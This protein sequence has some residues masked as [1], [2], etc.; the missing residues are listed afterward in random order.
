M[1]VHLNNVPKG[2]TDDK[3]WDELE[4]HV[5]ALGILD[6]Y[7]E[8]PSRR[9]FAWITFLNEADGKRF[10]QKHEKVTM[11]PTQPWS[12]PVPNGRFRPRTKDMARLQI[13]KTPIYVSKSTRKIDEGILLHL[14]IQKDE[15]RTVERKPVVVDRNPK[16]D[17]IST[18]VRHIACGKNMF[19]Q[20]SDD[21]IFI[22]QCSLDLRGTARF[23]RHALMLKFI[24]QDEHRVDIPYDIIQDLVADASGVSMTLVLTEPPRFYPS[25]TKW[26]RQT[27]LGMW[28]AHAKYVAHCL[29]YRITLSSQYVEV[30]ES[31]RSRDIIAVTRQQ[32]PVRRNPRPHEEDY[33]TCMTTFEGSIRS[34]SVSRTR[35][36]PFVVLFQLQGLVWNNYLHP[37]TALKMLEVMDRFAKDCKRSN[38]LLPFTADSMKTLFQKIPYP[39]PGTDSQDL[40]PEHLVASIVE[41]EQLR[42]EEDPTRA[43][44]Y[45]PPIPDSQTW[46]LKAIVT[47]TRIM[48]HG[49][50]AE[51]KN[52][53]LRMFPRHA[54][55]FVRVIFS[56]EDGQDLALFPSVNNSAI[57]E[58]YRKVLKD[59]I[60]IAGRKYDFLGFSHSSLRSH[61]AWFCAPFNDNME[62]HNNDSIIKSLGDFSEIRI[63]AKCAARIGQAFSETPYAV[64]ILKCGIGIKYIPD[65]KTKDG[66]RVFSDGVGTISWD[67]IEE[68]WDHLPTTSA[69][70]CLQVRLAGIKGMLSLDSRLKGKVVCIRKESMMK[71]PSNDQTMLGIC[72][73]ASKPLRLVLNRQ[74]IKILEDMGTNAE[75]FIDQQNKALD[76]LR[77]VTATATNTSTFLEYQL[78]G[79]TVGLPKLIKYLNKI[80]VD[81][82]RDNFMKTVVDHTILEELRLLKYKARIPVDQGVVLFGIMDETGFLEEGEI[83]VTFD[84]Q[85]DKI[86]GRVKQSLRDGFV[87]VTRSPALHPGDI[88]PAQMRTPPQ[89]HPLRDLKNCVVF[90]QKGT[91]DLPSQLSGGDLDGDLYSVFWDPYVIPKQFFEAASY[92]RVSPPSL[93][94]AVTR[95]DIADFF[96]RFMET[97][98]L[99][100]I[101]NRHQIIAD[102]KE[103]GTVHEQCI[104][105]AELHSTAVDY[106]KTG[107]PVKLLEL[108]KAPRIRPDFMASAP[109]TH[110][111]DRDEVDHIGDPDSDEDDDEDGMGMSKHRYYRSPK[112]LGELY[113]GVDEKKIWRE[114]VQRPIDKSGPSVWDSLVRHVRVALKEEGYAPS[115]IDYTRRIDDAWKLRELY[116]GEVANNMYQFSD[117]PRAPIKEVEAFCGS[118][119]NPRG[120]QTRRQRDSSIKLKEE[121]DKVMSF[122]VKQMR[123]RGGGAN[124]TTDDAASTAT[125]EDRQS[126]KEMMNAVEL[127][128]ACVIVGSE[129]VNGKRYMGDQKPLESFRVVAAS[130]LVK[131]LNEL[132]TRKRIGRMGGYVGVRSGP[133]FHG[134]LPLR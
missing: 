102:V 86:H 4:P 9:T 124:G 30:L 68:I 44:P 122:Y 59:G 88:Q 134:A 51:S 103:E 133:L 26:M 99:G 81:Y 57:F 55:Y 73:M 71:F 115:D 53:V 13:L 117:S 52:R 47:P 91:R 118:I 41:T 83:Y 45:G 120:S 104:K 37:A 108:P 109:P 31:L 29:V 95:D 3:L 33:S 54:D 101:A 64:D 112:I 22:E 107:I 7:C 65:V 67:A 116:E 121:M 123:D 106:S 1:E 24:D 89:G 16:A 48:L 19:D 61:S 97:D 96:V 28:P 70:T 132:L 12:P 11:L 63:P 84:Q 75:W 69:P 62:L 119:L 92:P 98:I 39:C 125:D 60:Q 93:D 105:L 78:V 32:L 38:V 127:C 56:D 14:K 25:F 74:T 15:R 110:L 6:W 79:T 18:N 129:A 17:P 130:C 58:R 113:R 85:Y 66:S 43:T 42:R 8:K 77:N 34:A 94:R 87:L 2:L 131:E 36:L 10:L 111:Y 114:D 23:G 27:A 21:L 20:G 50:D 49:P 72:D 35:L 100:V 46:V 76:I 90:S 40:S 80:G 5:K 126:E 82:R 128:W